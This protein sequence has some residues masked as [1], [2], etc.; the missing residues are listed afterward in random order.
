M[1]PHC[2]STTFTI[3]LTHRFH[4]LAQQFYNHH[5]NA[6]KAKQ[7]YLNTLSVQAVKFYLTCLGIDACLEKS[8]SWNPVVQVLSNAADLWVTDGGRLECCAVLPAQTQLDI[9]EEAWDDRIGYLFVQLN[10][11]LT[12]A[13]L[14]G[15]L[16]QLQPT[17]IPIQALQSIDRFPSYLKQVVPE[18]VAPALSPTRLQGWLDQIVDDSWTALNQLLEDWQ[19]PA[20]SFRT[21]LTNR[22]VIAPEATGI[23]QGKFLTLSHVSET[24]VLFLVGITPIEERQTFDITVELYPAGQDTYL[25]PC[26]QVV[27]MDET[28][29]PV[30]QAEGRQSEGLEF[31]FSAVSGENFTVQ[32]SL[33]QSV[34]TE[35]FYV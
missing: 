33:N 8:D 24:Q 2:P 26:L 7:I 23:K 16:P 13:T 14:L 12:E 19:T 1:T 11:S 32:I 5:R 10:N 9:P 30:L 20:F 3:P 31:Q 28:Q 6:Q 15:F 17:P 18:T 22:D 21:S 27:V 29:I 4:Q 34:I 35:L 25:P